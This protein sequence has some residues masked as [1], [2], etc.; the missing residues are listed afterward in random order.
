MFSTERL[1]NLTSAQS[2]EFAKYISPQYFKPY[3]RLYLFLI[4]RLEFSRGEEKT[5]DILMDEVLLCDISF[6]CVAALY[7][8]QLSDVTVGNYLIHKLQLAREIDK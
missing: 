7:S 5:V 8:L 3:L 4:R 6:A 2:L 1:E